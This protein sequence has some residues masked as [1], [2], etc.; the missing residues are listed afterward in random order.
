MTKQGGFLSFTKDDLA[1]INSAIAS[2][3]LTVLVDGQTITYR[4]IS[5]LL[6]AKNHIQQS[7]RKRR[8]AFSGFAVQVDRG[9]R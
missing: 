4:S 3:E 1:A 5:E 9:I 2:G 7:L 6:K 8:S